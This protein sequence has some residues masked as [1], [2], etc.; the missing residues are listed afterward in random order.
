MEAWE[1]CFDS[2]A[3]AETLSGILQ[4]R[5]SEAQIDR[6]ENAMIAQHRHRGIPCE[7]APSIREDLRE[8][9]EGSV[10]K[11]GRA[12]WGYTSDVFPGRVHT[13]RSQYPGRGIV[14]LAGDVLFERDP[15]GSLQP[16]TL[17]LDGLSKAALT[18]LK[19]DISLEAAAVYRRQLAEARG[20]HKAFDEARNV[21]GACL[22]PLMRDGI[23]DARPN[24]EADTGFLIPERAAGNFMRTVFY[25]R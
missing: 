16:E 6:V 21:L 9:V 20:N 4:A 22:I 7:T 19:S 15:E 8:L 14:V 25:H 1:L 12:I 18:L 5:A 3:P 11:I 10:R 24:I 13:L 17:A 23:S 2:E